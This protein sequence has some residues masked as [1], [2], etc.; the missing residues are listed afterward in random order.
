MGYVDASVGI[1]NGINFNGHKNRLGSFAAPQ[2]VFLDKAFLKTLPM[3]HILNGVCEII[4]LAVIKDATLFDL[5]E[6]RGAECAS[7]KF[8]DQAGEE[9][10][11]RAIM[12]M[13]EELEP[14]LFEENLARSVDFGHTFGYGLETLH[15]DHLLHGEAV[16]LDIALSVVIAQRRNL[17][18]EKELERIFN[19][20]SSLNIE[21]RTA[22]LDPALLWE[23]M[24]ERT[25]HRNGLQRV[26]LPDG[27]GSCVFV[28]DIQA[29][30]IQ[31]ACKT[32][33]TRMVVNDTI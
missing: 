25:Y 29:E 13:I 23:S 31:A 28:N 6:A 15:E 5:L 22:I 21:L 14:N 17:L 33:E 30:E 7:L 19:L 8:Q 12:G 1:K 9:I 2:K 24:L 3:R 11:N 32:L 26:P 16:I 20:I 18:S 27:I 10:L 4:K